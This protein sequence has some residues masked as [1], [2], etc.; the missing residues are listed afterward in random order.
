VCEFYFEQLPTTAN[1]KQ[2]V[3]ADLLF[4]GLFSILFLVSF[5]SLAHQWSLSKE[6]RGH[7][8]RS[9]IG[10]AIAFSFFSIFIWALHCAAAFRR[11]QI[12]VESDVEESLLPGPGASVRSGYT[13]FRG[14]GAYQ[15]IGGYTGGQGPPLSRSLKELPARQYRP[16][17]TQGPFSQSP[18][19]ARSPFSKDQETLSRSEQVLPPFSVHNTEPPASQSL[20]SEDSSDEDLIRY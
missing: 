14:A 8:G 11:L 9:N 16:E 4:S 5:S 19:V 17:T 15:D 12:G 1:R 6:P 10:A 7:Y 20:G 13:E 2:V 3:V 18:N